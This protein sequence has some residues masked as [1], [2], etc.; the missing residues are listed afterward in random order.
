MSANKKSHLGIFLKL[1]TVLGILAILLFTFGVAMTI[2]GYP[3]TWPFGGVEKLPRIELGYFD[4]GCLYDFDFE[5]LTYELALD[6]Y[7]PAQK[8]TVQ[9][10]VERSGQCPKEGFDV[11]GYWPS[12]LRVGIELKDSDENLWMGRFYLPALSF[13][14]S[15]EEFLT[16]FPKKLDLRYRR[17]KDF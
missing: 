10:S 17:Y 12:G 4:C 15:P 1:W 9:F 8:P 6:R 5:N 7:I 11:V 13:G 2:N 3:I 14:I 16:G